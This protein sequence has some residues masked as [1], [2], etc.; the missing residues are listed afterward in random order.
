[1]GSEDA[2]TYGVGVKYLFDAGWA[3]R[4]R[5]FTSLNLPF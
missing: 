4:N 2:T 3:Q 5:S 1:L